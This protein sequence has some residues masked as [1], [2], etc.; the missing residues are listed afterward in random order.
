MGFLPS[1]GGVPYTGKTSQHPESGGDAP[2]RKEVTASALPPGYSQDTHQKGLQEGGGLGNWGGRV[3][4][5]PPHSSLSPPA[6][7][8]IFY[9]P[10]RPPPILGFCPM[11]PGLTWS[12]CRLR[13][14]LDP[15]PSSATGSGCAAEPASACPERRSWGREAGGSLELLAPMTGTGLQ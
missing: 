12:S 13:E 15:R 10:A 14:G 7:L 11:P 3:S 8:L 4:T 1:W 6:P 9:S 2:A 5:S